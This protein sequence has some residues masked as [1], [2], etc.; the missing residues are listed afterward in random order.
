M[1]EDSRRYFWFPWSGQT[2]TFPTYIG[3]AS[4][5]ALPWRSPNDNQKVYVEE[6]GK[7]MVK[8]LKEVTRNGKPIVRVNAGRMM[9]IV[10]QS[11]YAGMADWLVEIL[12]APAESLEIKIYALESLRYL[13]AIRRKEKPNATIF[14]DPANLT[15]ITEALLK[16]VTEK[17]DFQ[18]PAAGTP[19]ANSNAGKDAI[20]RMRVFMFYRRKAVEAVASLPVGV[21]ADDLGRISVRP[22]HTLMMIALNDTRIEPPVTMRERIE[23]MI[24]VLN[25]IPDEKMNVDYATYGMAK[26][27]QELVR[28]RA[29]GL[30]S[31][32]WKQ[33]AARIKEAFNHGREL[34]KLKNVANKQMVIDLDR[35]ASELLTP[36]IDKG[37]E[38]QVDANKL[39]QWITDNPL[40]VNSLF[41][42]DAKLFLDPR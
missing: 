33:S 32:P 35:I 12:N 1:V 3:A 18:V 16:I 21:I 22:A 2:S 31:V 9:T 39:N 24:G 8:H 37:L 34:A 19:E 5:V 25:M 14:S 41:L 26:V 10:A 13:L 7:A 15:K 29:Q 28:E 36:V 30:N 42:D 17:P 40:K 11:G 4:T 6:F 23:A 38:A 27:L 20:D